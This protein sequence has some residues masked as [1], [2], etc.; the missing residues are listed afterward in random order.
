[1]LVSALGPELLLALLLLAPLFATLVS[2]LFEILDLFSFCDRNRPHSLEIATAVSACSHSFTIRM[3]DKP[4]NP[5]TIAPVDAII[6]VEVLIEVDEDI[7]E[8]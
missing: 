5:A 1:M 4:K 2:A 8:E 3:I 7:S 6:T